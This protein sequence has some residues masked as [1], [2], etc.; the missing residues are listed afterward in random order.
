MAETCGREWC[1]AEVIET[2]NFGLS[3]RAGLTVDVVV[4]RTVVDEVV[5]GPVPE[6]ARASVGFGG[7]VQSVASGVFGSEGVAG[8]QS[9]GSAGGASCDH[10]VIV[11]QLFGGDGT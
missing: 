5:G 11:R 6:A 7:E 3:T 1:V 8:C 2:H 9:H 10:N 4:A